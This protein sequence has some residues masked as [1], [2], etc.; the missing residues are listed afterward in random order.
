MYDNNDCIERVVHFSRKSYGRIFV[1]KEEDI[2]EVHNIIKGMDEYEFENYMPKDIVCVFDK[3]AVLT[4]THKF[5]D[6][7]LNDLMYRCWL[8]GIKCFYAN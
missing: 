5:T 2:I 7:D 8:N 4:Y 6:I 3:D 1:E